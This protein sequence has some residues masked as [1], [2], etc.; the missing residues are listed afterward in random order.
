MR[1]SQQLSD[2]GR[3]M[4][5]GSLIIAILAFFLPILAQAQSPGSF[6]FADADG[7]GLIGGPDLNAL[8]AIL[9]NLAASDTVYYT[10]YP[11]SR[12]RQDTDGNGLIG[13]P[14]ANIIS[15]W[16]NGTWT[17]ISGGPGTLLLE[18]N[19]THV[20]SGS[21]VLVG[22]Y[23]TS[24]ST[25]ALRTGWGIEFQIA[26]NSPCQTAVIYGYS[27]AGGLAGGS[28]TADYGWWHQA[29]KYTPQ[30]SA[31]FNAVAWVNVKPTGCTVGQHIYIKVFVPSDSEAVNSGG[32][33]PS[34]LDASVL[35]DVAVTSSATLV[36]LDE[37]PNPI[38][39]PVLGT[40]QLYVVGTFSDG[41]TV[42]CTTTC[43][44]FSTAYAPGAPLLPTTPLP[45]PP[46]RLFLP[47]FL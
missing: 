19:T 44:G 29:Y 14:D 32:R 16:L 3:S 46:A 26:T 25:G 12:Y 31:P 27:V 1:L 37:N 2:L 7:N 30:P 11:V 18:A 5:A 10:G 36:S 13:G 35:L 40:Q 38:T 17:N 22:A 23:A 42:D 47:P 33:F 9:N 45:P 34:E 8:N 41:S 4:K 21:S 43:G 6:Y 28:T 39:I 20:A 15:Q 24:I